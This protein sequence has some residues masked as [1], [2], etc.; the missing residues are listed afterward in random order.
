MGAPGQARARTRTR[1]RTPAPAP[2]P[3]PARTA[4]Y[5]RRAARPRPPARY[6]P[7]L[8]TDHGQFGRHPAARAPKPVVRGSP[9]GTRT[10]CCAHGSQRAPSARWWPRATVTVESQRRPTRSARPAPFAP[11]GA[12]TIEPPH[13]AELPATKSRHTH[14]HGP[15]NAGTSR[16]APAPR[17]PDIPARTRHR[18]PSIRRRFA[19]IG[20]RPGFLPT[21]SA[22]RAPPTRHRSGLKLG[23]GWCGKDGSG[24]LQLR[25]WAGWGFKVEVNG[26]SG[27]PSLGERVRRLRG[28]WGLEVVVGCGVGLSPR[29]VT[30]GISGTWRGCKRRRL[31]SGRAF[32][33][34]VCTPARTLIW[35]APARPRREPHPWAQVCGGSV[36][37][38]ARCGF[39]HRPWCAWVV[40][41]LDAESYIALPAAPCCLFS[42]FQRAAVP[43]GSGGAPRRDI[44]AI[45]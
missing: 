20:G 7:A 10:S 29:S 11:A 35:A 40:R 41:S 9:A 5:R 23:T 4:D 45:S 28:G 36:A 27:R 38:C 18:I 17:H 25:A 15:H 3:A 42:L 22:V 16:P 8:L 39:V 24:A 32:R 43:W 30:G 21:G 12:M 37:R 2:A 33:F 26:A 13:P 1:T 31:R 34:A 14:C 6:L 44:S 19:R